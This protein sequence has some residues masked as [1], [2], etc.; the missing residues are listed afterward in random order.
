MYDRIDVCW[1]FGVWGF[2][3]WECCLLGGK[4][5]DGRKMGVREY[6]RYYIWC[7]LVFWGS[8]RVL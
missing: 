1:V 6:D 8:R 7:F 4:F 2:L 5:I 3:Y